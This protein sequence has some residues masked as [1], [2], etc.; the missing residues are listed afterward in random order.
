MSRFVSNI[1]SV[2]GSA[3]PNALRRLAG[4]ESDPV[5]AKS[6]LMP[7]YGPKPLRLPKPNDAR[8]VP[9]ECSHGSMEFTPP[10]SQFSKSA[11][12]LSK[13]AGSTGVSA[14]SS[15]SAVRNRKRKRWPSAA[16]T[17]SPS[18]VES[19][20]AAGCPAENDAYRTGVPE[21]QVA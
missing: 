2:Y 18:V 19:K 17:V 15:M 16:P 13:E 9:K 5:G 14:P 4:I 11:I 21:R 3:L 8:R 1:R 6:A 7:M 10:A 12:I 20:T